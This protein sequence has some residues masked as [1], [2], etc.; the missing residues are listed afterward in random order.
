MATLEEEF[1]DFV[2]YRL[3]D[4]IPKNS[5]YRA[6]HSLYE[7]LSDLPEDT[8]EI[9]NEIEGTASER[10]YRLGFLDGI[11]LMAGM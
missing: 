6:I 10:A 4:I 2:A 8:R 9:V 7:K 1:C 5:K 3:G 11:Q